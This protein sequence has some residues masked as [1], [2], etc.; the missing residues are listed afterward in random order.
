MQGEM[1]K[2]PSHHFT[3]STTLVK[4]IAVQETISKLRG[5]KD[6]FIIFSFIFVGWAQLD[7]SPSDSHCSQMSAGAAVI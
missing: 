4:G 5:L 3:I 7:G 1:W 2:T 6:Q